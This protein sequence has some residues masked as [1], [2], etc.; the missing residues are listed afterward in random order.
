VKAGLHLHKKMT[1]GIGIKEQEKQRPQ[2]DRKNKRNEQTFLRKKQVLPPTTW[3]NMHPMS[4]ISSLCHI[5]KISG[6]QYHRMETHLSLA[7]VVSRC[8]YVT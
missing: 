8:W 3:Q 6:I 5:S 4:Q 1:L 7:Q 2:K